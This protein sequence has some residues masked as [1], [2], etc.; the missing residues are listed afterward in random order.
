MQIY[1]MINISWRFPW[2]K[3]ITIYGFY[4]CR[5]EIVGLK[6]TN[7]DISNTFS[8]LVAILM[9]H[10]AKQHRLQ[11]QLKKKHCL[12]IAII[13]WNVVAKSNKTTWNEYEDY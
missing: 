7:N 4:G 3:K 6:W 2:T 9:D 13:E 10:C 1:G 12:R 8:K 11:N 5:K